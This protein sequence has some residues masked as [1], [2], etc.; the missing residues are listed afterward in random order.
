MLLPSDQPWLQHTPVLP[1]SKRWR[2]YKPLGGY[3]L[4]NHCSPD[5]E[6]EEIGEPFMEV[7]LQVRGT[8]G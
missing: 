4:P 1:G 2:L 3:E 8:G 7:T 5:L 6:Q